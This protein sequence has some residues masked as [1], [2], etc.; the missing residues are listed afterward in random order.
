MGV[1]WCLTVAPCDVSEQLLTTETPP[2]GREKPIRPPRRSG[3]RGTAACTAAPGIESVST[4]TGPSGPA[5]TQLGGIPH[6]V[7]SL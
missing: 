2:C 4:A 6:A 7:P 5:M 3:P 1:L